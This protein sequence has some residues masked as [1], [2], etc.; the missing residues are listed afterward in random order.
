M[1]NFLKR[2]RVTEAESGH[3][4]HVQQRSQSHWLMITYT[5]T[6]TIHERS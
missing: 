4:E 6:P 1:Q 3:K 5:K 2:I